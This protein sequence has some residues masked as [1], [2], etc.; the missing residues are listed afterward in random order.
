MNPEPLRDDEQVLHQGG[1]WGGMR[2]ARP[3]S[4]LRRALS[5]RAAGGH[6]YLTPTRLIWV[7][8]FLVWG[9]VWR[10]GTPGLM[11]RV[12]SIELSE[13]QRFETKS[14]WNTELVIE[15]AEWIYWMRFGLPF[16]SGAAFIEWERA[17]QDAL[18]A[19]GTDGTGGAPR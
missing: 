3:Q 2:P 15:T 16:P 19:S 11:P 14:T 12:A 7:R 17:I 6:L 4:L 1:A 9:R 13:I 8:K 5:G 18:A 10:V